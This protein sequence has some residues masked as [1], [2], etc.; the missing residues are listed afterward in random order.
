MTA[1]MVSF[2][3]SWR[4]IVK[5]LKKFFY[6]VVFV[7]AAIGLYIL[8][9]PAPQLDV[10][11]VDLDYLAE[12]GISVET[13]TS[14]EFKRSAVL[15]T[16]EG[17]PESLASTGATSIPSSLSGSNSAPSF[18]AS[19]AK[20]ES[21]ISSDSKVFDEAPAFVAFSAI[22]EAPAFVP[23]PSASRVALQFESNVPKNEDKNE[24]TA[25]KIRADVSPT[26]ENVPPVPVEPPVHLD[27]RP[28]DS[29]K[30]T[31]SHENSPPKHQDST[32]PLAVGS[33]PFP[34]IER[35]PIQ[36]NP[37]GTIENAAP[38]PSLAP[39]E[40]LEGFDVSGLIREATARRNDIGDLTNQTEQSTKKKIVS[41]LSE[42]ESESLDAAFITSLNVSDKRE[43][44]M[45]IYNIL[46]SDDV[47]PK[48]AEKKHEMDRPKVASLKKLPAPL[49]QSNVC[50][51]PEIAF[52]ENTAIESA[53]AE[54]SNGVSAIGA[55]QVA[56]SAA[57]SKNAVIPIEYKPTAIRTSAGT[58]PIFEPI[59][60]PSEIGSIISFQPNLGY[61]PNQKAALDN[62]VSAVSSENSDVGAT[63]KME[64]LTS[65]N[66]TDESIAAVA[67]VSRDNFS[68]LTNNSNYISSS[69]IIGVETSNQKTNN[70][71]DSNQR[72]SLIKDE[73]IRAEMHEK[74]PKVRESVRASILEQRL[75]ME[76]GDM[77]K[78]R[79]A[80]MQLSRLYDNSKLTNEERDMCSSLLDIL[81][82]EIIYAQDT[83]VLEPSYLVKPK[84][85]IEL[86][87]EKFAM[88]PALLRKLNGIDAITEPEI[89]SKLK[90]VVGRFDA[91]ISTQR[92]EMTLILGGLYAGRFPVAIGG[93]VSSYL[94]EFSVQSVAGTGS[95]RV[96][97]L[98][99]G[100]TLRFMSQRITEDQLA[101]SV[102]F[103]DKDAI[104]IF[105]ILDVGSIIVIE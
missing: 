87:A 32:L 82:L 36:K 77:K 93:G 83:H 99:N 38:F 35:T 72:Q 8:L 100:I 15:N 21:P 73:N 11:D 33:F 63:A 67:S 52:P 28:P 69:T 59:G 70:S 62:S 71:I 47:A 81:A 31:L 2:S 14:N 65:P 13:G 34:D 41:N 45:T 20:T 58:P 101:L 25:D 103:A 89:G 80:F 43:L 6:C 3:V 30:K 44:Q 96:V 76:S 18:M 7:F 85:T 78:K 60:T 48:N 68:A 23:A 90:V 66:S 10:P 5:R 54:A 102:R 64:T 50:R 57:R 9:K 55:S 74:F 40:P 56:S 61:L 97:S 91:N 92:R 29:E 22:D 94:G 49:E 39:I 46:S 27:S 75:L 98:S 53:I 51:L 84:D 12:I 19:V 79:T 26:I 95:D 86:I 37:N 88:T 105:D 4:V 17:L 104:E 1:W 42:N 24:G 16:V